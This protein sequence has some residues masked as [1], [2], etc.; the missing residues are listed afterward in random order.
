MKKRILIVDD[1]RNVRLNYRITLETEGYEITEADSGADGLAKLA[2][3]PFGLAIL[4]LRMPEMDGI[5]LLHKMRENK[6]NTPVIIITAFGDVPHAVEAMK[7]GAIDFL[8]KP[9]K[10][11]ELRSIAEDI[12]VRHT[13]RPPLE[14]QDTDTFNAH[15]TEAKRLINLQLFP[16]AWKR[17]SRA[18]ELNPNSPEALNLA[19]VFFEMQEDFDRARKLYGKAIKCGPYFEPAQQNMRRIY[20]LFQFGS[21]NEPF[22]LGDEV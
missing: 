9:I 5:A 6:N 12:F 22:N 20:E 13:P 11:E 3:G 14:E 16:A 7:L 18:L 4:D 8:Q 15:F 2:Q 10:P 1:E 17:L 21:S 19:G